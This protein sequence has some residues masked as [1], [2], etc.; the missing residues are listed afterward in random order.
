MR[1]SNF[2][3]WRGT[4]M[5]FFVSASYRSSNHFCFSAF[6]SKKLNRVGAETTLELF[7][8]PGSGDI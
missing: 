5:H 7:R 3:G 4:G 6:H 1:I 8:V 2:V